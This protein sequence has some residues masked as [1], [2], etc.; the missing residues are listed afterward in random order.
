MHHQSYVQAQLKPRR[1]DERRIVGEPYVGK[2]G[3][4]D[5]IRADRVRRL[6]ASIESVA[7][8]DVVPPL[9]AA[10]V[11]AKHL[12]GPATDAAMRCAECLDEERQSRSGTLAHRRTPLVIATCCHHL[13]TWESYPPEG[14]AFFSAIGL[15]RTEFV[16]VCRLSHWATITTDGGDGCCGGD[17]NGDETDPT[18][19]AHGDCQPRHGKGGLPTLSALSEAA[20]GGARSPE[21]ETGGPP[22]DRGQKRRLGEQCKRALDWGRVYAL[23]ARGFGGR[24]RLLRYTRHSVESR[25]IVAC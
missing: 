15:G 19:D 20:S 1:C 21:H 9:Q 17:G 3:C 8:A 6:T 7:L 25:L 5:G 10:V 22:L 16:T 13:C 2:Q 11:I 24:V 18:R 4:H 14:Q 12:C 23:E